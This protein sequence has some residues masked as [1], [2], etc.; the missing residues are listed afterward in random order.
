[1]KGEIMSLKK[2]KSDAKS[3]ENA[4]RASECGESGEGGIGCHGRDELSRWGK[5]GIHHVWS[6]K[7]YRPAR[8][9]HLCFAT[10]IEMRESDFE[11]TRKINKENILYQKKCELQPNSQILRVNHL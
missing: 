9:L 4:G 1:M 7:F 11:E 3:P 6:S 8:K 2:V 5:S 10:Y